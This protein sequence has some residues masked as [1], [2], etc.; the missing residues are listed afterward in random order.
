M[1]R[2]VPTKAIAAILG[3]SAFAV[4]IV[5]GLGSDAEASVILLRALVSL[6]GCYLLGLFVG[7][8]AA[9]AVREHL[10][11]LGGS[12][13]DVAASAAPETKTEKNS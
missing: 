13:A 12:A 2:P 3:L 4:A 9:V 6:G 11:Q 1:N 8:A 7:E 10:S 5:S